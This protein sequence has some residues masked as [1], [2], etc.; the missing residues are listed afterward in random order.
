MGRATLRSLLVVIGLVVAPL[1]PQAIPANEARTPAE[2]FERKATIKDCLIYVARDLTARY[3]AASKDA[4]TTEPA[5][6]M[7][8]VDSTRSMANEL[9][10]LKDGLEELWMEGPPGLRIG[11]RGIRNA[12]VL[13]PTRLDGKVSSALRAITYLPQEGLRDVYEPIERAADALAREDAEVKALLLISEE[14]AE[15]EGDVERARDALFDCGAAFYCIAGEAAFESRWERIFDA[16][17]DAAQGLGERF[18]PA[19]RRLRPGEL[20]RGGEVAFGMVPYGWELNLV[21]TCFR[22]VRPPDYPVPSG[23]GFWGLASLAHTS[24]GRYFIYDFPA[25]Q[26]TGKQAKQRKTL[27]ETSRLAGLAPDL[28]P[29]SKILKA[30]SKDARAKTV[31]R[32]W[33]HLANEATPLLQE[34]GT[35]ERRGAS[36][37]SRPARLLRA[38]PPSMSWL[39]DLDEV[40]RAMKDVGTRIALLDQA[41][42][43]WNTTAGRATTGR[44]PSSLHA[45]IE[46]NFRLLGAQ[47]RKARFHWGEILAALK[48]IKPL[49]VTYRRVRLVPLHLFRGSGKGYKAPQ[50]GHESRQSRLADLILMQTQLA[51]RYHGTPWALLVQKGVTRTYNKHV[52]L[53]ERRPSRPT[54]TREPKRNGKRG[55]DGPAA[56]PPK[57]PPKPP[58][59]PRPGSGGSGP[60]TGG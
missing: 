51:E 32:I 59:G 57:P 55:K 26:V 33:E 8:L 2:T 24:G 11:V 45:R 13:N 16:R 19:P 10:A 9:A 36:L 53:L 6:L 50:L 48:T 52:Q 1:P 21:Q 60:T 31:V 27:Y 18:N 44:P 23:F 54:K 56:P 43:W 49:D 42:S 58:P 35:L 38:N 15:A 20:W 37:G 22:W 30:L 3:E 34:L 46:A 41:L 14:G 25:R 40:R 17:L 12:Q 47:L 7:L 29:R 4:K 5:V 28:R 39:N